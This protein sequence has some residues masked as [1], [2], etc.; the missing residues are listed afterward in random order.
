M[1]TTSAPASRRA[2]NRLFQRAKGAVGGQRRLWRTIQNNLMRAGRYAYRDRRRRRRDLRSLWIIR[3]SAAVQ[4]EGMRY[5]QFIYGLGKA[6]IEL[7][8]KMLSELA[9]HDAVAFS[10][11]VEAV[12]KALAA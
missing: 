3:I 5:S 11:V 10:A 6:N 9:I 8:R 12:K 4:A 1:R 7:N 2:K